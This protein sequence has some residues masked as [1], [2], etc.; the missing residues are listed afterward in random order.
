MKTK[1]ILF[2]LFA[3][4]FALSLFA[5]GGESVEPYPNFGLPRVEEMMFLV[6]QIGIIL[7]HLFQY[8]I[9][10]FAKAIDEYRK[11]HKEE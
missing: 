1:K 3:G 11:Q 10:I 8:L 2:A 9:D 7:P 5:N 6:L 4:L